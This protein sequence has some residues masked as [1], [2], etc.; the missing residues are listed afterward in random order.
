TGRGAGRQGLCRVS[1]PTAVGGGHRSG[2]PAQRLVARSAACMAD[3]TAMTRLADLRTF[4]ALMDR[5][6]AKQGGP[7]PLGALMRQS[8]AP[9]GVYFFFEAGEHR[10]DSGDG[11]R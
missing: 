4:Y 8:I 1:S 2:A 3:R 6:A 5:L 11:P 9:R 10:T 7:M